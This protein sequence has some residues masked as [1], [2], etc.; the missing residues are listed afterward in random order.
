MKPGCYTALATPFTP[1]GMRIDQKGLE[2]LVAFQIAGGIT[3]ILAVGTTGESPTLAWNEHNAVMDTVARLSRNNC[4]VHC[5]APAAT[6]PRRPSTPPSTL[7]AGRWM[8]CC[9]WT[10]L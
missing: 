1:D 7:C 10:L 2:Q 5:R 8:P 4:L 3:G 6:T 9:W